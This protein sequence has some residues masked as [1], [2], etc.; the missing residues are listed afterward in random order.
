MCKGGTAVGRSRVLWT[1][2]EFGI[3]ILNGL[4]VLMFEVITNLV[5]CSGRNFNTGEVSNTWSMCRWTRQV[6]IRVKLRWTAD[7]T[8]GFDKM[9][10]A[11]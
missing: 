3:R 7:M 9:L 10:C 5:I 11:S 6:R 2:R 1:R 4:I 8:G